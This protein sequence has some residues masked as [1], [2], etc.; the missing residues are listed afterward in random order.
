M[1]SK[2]QLVQGFSLF[3]C[4]NRP[5]T[6]NNVMNQKKSHFIDYAI[7]DILITSVNELSTPNRL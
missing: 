7:F 6:N 2:V 3:K 5:I 4:L 1:H